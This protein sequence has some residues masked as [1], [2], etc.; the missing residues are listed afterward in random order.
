[1]FAA[2]ATGNT[3]FATAMRKCFEDTIKF[4]EKERKAIAA[5]LTFCTADARLLI[6][7]VQVSWNILEE[8]KRGE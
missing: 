3:V 2:G 7:A 8:H 6:E 5:G 4:E 1:M